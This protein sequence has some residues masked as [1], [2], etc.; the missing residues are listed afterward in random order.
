M[1]SLNLN[2]QLTWVG[3]S[4]AKLRNF[5]IIMHTPYGTT[6]N[7]YIL[8]GS[9]K[10]ALI[11]TVKLD[12]VEEYIAKVESI[13]SIDK[14]DYL[15]VNHTEPDHV[16]S[17]ARILQINPDIIIV[18]TAVAK[19]YIKEILNCEFKF[20][21]IKDDETLS[22]GADV[23]LQFMMLP[24]LHWPDTMYTYC[25]ELKTLFT[26]DSF[27]AHY[28]HDEV[29]LSKVSHYD[30]YFS[31]FKYYFDMILG[32]FKIPY[33]LNA[34]DRIATLEFKMICTGH[35]PVVD[36]QIDMILDLYRTWSTP[37][38]NGR[39]SVVIAYVSAYGYTEKLAQSIAQGIQK[40]EGIDVQLFD[41]ELNNHEDVMKQ[42][43]YAD[44]IL[45]GSPT[46]LKAPLEPIMALTLSMITPA[47]SKKLASAFGSYGWS[48]EAVSH[49]C[50]RF[51]Q[52]KLKV[53]PGFKVKFNPTIQELND[54]QNF[55]MA[56]AQKIIE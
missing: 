7:S 38:K 43:S 32:P 54:A 50:E 44:G 4:D 45:L 39:K 9:E 31:A 13:I 12:F 2:K 15:I 14:I 5:D 36:T 53:M 6:Y 40:V 24:N 48:G 56:F 3:V 23:N 35:G 21:A 18:G 47:F 41:M 55:G 20:H 46:I 49:L 29:L 8:Q 22:L 10:I 11:E 27:G 42:I 28:A 33:V 1:N 52:L 25:K 30:D 19:M 34:L 16:G 17:I 51:E 37:I 26:C